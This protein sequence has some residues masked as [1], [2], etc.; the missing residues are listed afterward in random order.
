MPAPSPFVDSVLGALLALGPVHAR[1]MFGSWG[2]FLDDA[3]FGLIAGE[4]LYFKVDA[5]T[6]LHFS[7]AGAEAFT[8]QRQGKRVALSYREAPGAGPGQHTAA[9][10]PWAELGLEAARRARQKRRPKSRH[11]PKSRRGKDPRR[12]ERLQ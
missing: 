10:L 1:A 12:K 9:L 8:Y 7:T 3:M 11:G 6:E 2:L 4:R 5:E